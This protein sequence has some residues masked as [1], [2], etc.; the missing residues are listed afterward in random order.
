MTPGQRQQP[1]ENTGEPAYLQVARIIGAD[2]EAGVLRPGDQLRSI[3]QMCDDFHVSAS[4]IKAAMSVLRNQ[5]LIIGMQGKGTFV[6]RP[7]DRDQQPAEAELGHLAAELSQIRQALRD[8]G[9]RLA[10]IEAAVFPSESQ[11]R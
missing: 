8:V 4:V 7:E 3:N 2:I 1:V 9:D 5:N 10:A 6:T 11:S